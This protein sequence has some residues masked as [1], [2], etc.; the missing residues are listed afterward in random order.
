VTAQT[1][2]DIVDLLGRHGVKPVHR[3][4]Q[5]F[6]ADANITRRIVTESGVGPGQKVVEIGAGTGTLTRALVSAGADVVA[7]ELDQRLRP[8]LEETVGSGAELRFEDVTRIDLP[9]TFADG[10]W[11]MVANL[12]YNVGTP[13]V[14]EVLRSVPTIVRLVVMVQRE[15]AERFVARV[16]D[17]AYGLPSV[18]AAL[19]SRARLVMKVPPQVFYPAPNVESA[20]VVM[21]RIEASPHSERAVEL[22]R[23]AFSQRRKMLRSSLASALEDPATSLTA[24]GI[25]PT[26]RAENLSAADYLRLAAS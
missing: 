14:M 24:V 3:L 25:D 12:P 5:H 20:V 13:L 19:Y 8:I 17:D 18:V 26:A 7:Y 15:V 10:P 11:V 2:S 6:L 22:A 4:G 21:D 9:A 16:G 1:R 23:T